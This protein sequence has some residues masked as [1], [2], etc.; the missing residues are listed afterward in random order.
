MMQTEL[1]MTRRASVPL[2][3]GNMAT[4][5][6]IFPLRAA[7]A[8]VNL[9]R[10]GHGPTVRG[11]LIFAFRGRGLSNCGNPPGLASTQQSLY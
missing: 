3:D 5:D 8:D 9:V 2:V 6:S 10:P 4:I 11:L 7:Q 1:D